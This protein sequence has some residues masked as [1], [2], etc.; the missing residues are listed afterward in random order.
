MAETRII[1]N[2]PTTRRNRRVL[3]RTQTANNTPTVAYSIP[4]GQGRVTSV[5]AHATVIQSDF[6]RAGSVFAEGVFRRAVGGNVTRASG[7]GGISK[8]LLR[9][10]GDFT[11]VMPSIDLVA[12]TANQTIDL[13]VTGLNATTLNWHIEIN[14]LQNLT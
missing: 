9:S 1:Q 3:E 8:P 12:N 13:E 2:S 5:E 11:G 7:N 6:S 4:L 14:S 10:I